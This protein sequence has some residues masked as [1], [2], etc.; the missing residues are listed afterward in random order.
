M[1]KR[2]AIYAAAVIACAYAVPVHAQA[3]GGGGTAQ[4]AY[5]HSLRASKLVGMSVYNE[6]NQNI[7]PI[8]EIM[9]D[10]KTGM[11]T[12]IL[13]VG[14]YVGGGARLVEV[15]I[16]HVKLTAGKAMMPGATK[17]MLAGMPAVSVPGLPG[18]GH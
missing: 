7:G 11:A 13:S 10:E 3:P 5:E 18:A 14:T 4:V 6:Q 8:V 16:T 17:P 2:H 12:A 1:L 9:V 15:P